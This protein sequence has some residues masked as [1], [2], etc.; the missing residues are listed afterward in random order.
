MALA[1][2]ASINA[3]MEKE[4][5]HVPTNHVGGPPLY[6]RMMKAI[7]TGHTWGNRVRMVKL[8]LIFAELPL[9]AGAIAQFFWLTEAL[10]AALARHEGHPMVQRVKELN[11]YLTL[12]YAADLEQML[13][14][15]WRAEA[16]RMRTAATA[17]YC[18]TLAAAGP[19]ELVAAAF[20]LYGAL[21]VGGGKMTQQKVKKVF[22]Q[23]D[24]VLFDVAPDMKEVRAHF[25]NTFT[26]IGKEWPE[27]FDTLEQQAAR[28]MALNNTVVF[29]V[30]CWG[31]RATYFAAGVAAANIALVLALRWARS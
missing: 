18:D 21:V 4:M 23:C 10:E 3:A 17:S 11:L 8:P 27:H 24:H 22:P 1:E 26:A 9:Y 7:H 13:G 29:S 25:K 31:S 5:N 28:Y 14:P 19:V 2:E 15:K 16:V 12:G 30:R 6:G 20:I